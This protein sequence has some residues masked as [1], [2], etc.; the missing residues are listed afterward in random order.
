MNE[1]MHSQKSDCRNCYKCIRHCPVK[2]I[3]FVDNQAHII[4]SECIL[5][6]QCYV[7]CPQGAKVIRPDLDRAKKL[8]AGGAPVYA[9]LAPSFIANYPGTSCATMEAALKRL[10]FAAAEE[11]ALGATIVKRE[12]DRMVDE[13]QQDVVISSCCHSVNLLIQ[14]HYPEALKYLAK[15]QSPMQAHCAEIKREH[16][17][18][19][20]VFIGPCIS[21]KDE[22]D[23]Y[24]GIVD[25]VLTF[26]ELSQ[27]L[28]EE[29][30][31]P[32]QDTDENR[33][34]RARL[35]P[36]TGGILRTM[37]CDNADVSYLAVD[38]TENCIHTLEDLLNGKISNCF[39]EMSACVGSCI[40]GPITAKHGLSPVRSFMAVDRF[41]GKEDFPVPEVAP[42]LLEKHVASMEIRREIPGSAAIAEIL[43][44]MGKTS[45]E[46]EL[47][48]GSC[49]YNTC[50]EKAIAVFNGKADL[51]MCLP[52]LKEKAESFSDNIIK[53]TPNG[54]LVLNEQLE[55]QQ[56]NRAACKIMNIKNA[57]DILGDQVVRVLDP[58]VF[59]DVLQSGRAV[60][61]RRV[62]LAEYQ[63]YVELTVIYD[64]SYHIVMGFMRDV[65]DE[66]DERAK[67]ET[68]SRQTIEITD[69]VIEKQM[70]VVQEI[71]SLLGETTAETKIALTNL[72]ESL[73]DE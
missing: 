5:C 59:F 58:T 9:S 11:T 17:E 69:K 40:G 61:D 56:I 44:Q 42:E 33:Q 16:P 57:G 18:A 24:P 65:T 25:C 2:S 1:A 6:G 55:V 64:K 22:G 30:I 37:K 34:S 28:A 7:V 15:I 47:N 66:E 19:K 50:R 62:Y 41:A 14:K 23:L 10:G 54:I 48:C 32:E 3:R 43:R 67:K 49:G 4:H 70:R 21:K 72:K 35:F 63:K 36:T 26:E 38:G 29:S 53:N 8:I 31:V 60:R 52:F 71:A 68:L 45:P 51:T 27:W 39:I 73:N 20:T 13:K 46:Q 12:Y